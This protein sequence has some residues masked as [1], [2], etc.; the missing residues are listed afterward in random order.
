MDH[1][2]SHD[3]SVFNA[4]YMHQSSFDAF[5]LQVIISNL[6]GRKTKL[7]WVCTGLATREDVPNGDTCL[8]PVCR[9]SKNTQVPVSAGAG[10]HSS[11]QT[12]N[13]CLSSCFTTP[14]LHAAS[15]PVPPRFVFISHFVRTF[16]TPVFLGQE[17]A[18]VLYC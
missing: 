4:I 10:I 9:Q 16:H 6:L 7:C 3:V 18:L 13:P 17:Q 2:N 1:G 5:K 8:R 15:S 12:P 11:E 14:E